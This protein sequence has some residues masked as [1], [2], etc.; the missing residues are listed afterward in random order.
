MAP[1]SHNW[2]R[3]CCL[4]Q[5]AGTNTEILKEPRCSHFLW[6]STYKWLTYSLC[7]LSWTGK[8]IL[9]LKNR[10]SSAVRAFGNGN[11]ISSILKHAFK[12]CPPALK[13]HQLHNVKQVYKSQLTYHLTLHW[14]KQANTHS[15]V[16][17]SS[18][19]TFFSF[20]GFVSGT[21]RIQ[22]FQQWQPW[23]H[24]W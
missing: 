23:H 4:G 9:T 6:L 7:I 10:H 20:I 19:H 16:P 24:S 11:T 22:I 18:A 21:I 1:N 12:W 2:L 15:S 5:T 3:Q 8:S 13:K 14:Q 17:I